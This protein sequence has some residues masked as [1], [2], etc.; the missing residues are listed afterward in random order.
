MSKDIATISRTNEILEKYQLKAQKKFGQNF[1]IDANVVEKIAKS[2]CDKEHTTIEIGPGIGSL[3]EML[4]R[5]S[6]KVISYEIDEHLLEV[7]DDT[8]SAYDNVEIVF[9]DFLNLDLTTVPYKDEEII[10]CA[11]LPYYITTPI[12]FKLFESDL[13]IK[14]IS[15][16]VQKEVADRF[17]ATVNSKDYNALS[18][19]VQYAYDVRLLMNVS[20][21]VFNPK[22]NVDSAV[23]V[24]EP[25]VK[26]PVKDEKEFYDM[27]KLAFKQRRKTLYNN[28]REAFEG[29][30]IKKMFA[31]L[32]IKETARAQELDLA[33]FIKMYEVLYVH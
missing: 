31:K 28:L 33:T 14:R 25:K 7:L 11:N 1:L 13:K 21:H 12:L 24:F 23:I 30:T 27:V 10:V 4:A 32:N 22:P 16:M 6:K 3:T 2:S 18:V 29:E 26:T 20:K 5:Y 17:K 15:V 19:I 8:L 9:Q